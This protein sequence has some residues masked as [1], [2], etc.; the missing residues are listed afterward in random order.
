MNPGKHSF[1]PAVSEPTVNITGDFRVPGDKSLSHRALMAGHLTVGQTVIK[2]LLRA[3]D[4]MNTLQAMRALGSTI[5]DRQQ[6]DEVTVNGL[7]TGFSGEPEN[8]IDFGN[9]GTGARL[10]M[11][12]C[13]TSCRFSVFTGDVSLRRRPMNRV[14]DPLKHF[15]TEFYG[16]EGGF[17]PL[18]VKGSVNPRPAE[19]RSD[20]PS[21]QIKSAF[22]LAAL[23]APGESVF[24]EAEP[25]RDHT[26]K[27][28]SAFGADIQTT[29]NEQGEKTIRVKGLPSLTPQKLDIPGDP[30]SAAFFIVAALITPGSEITVRNVL[31]NPY[32]T[33]LF[34]TLREMGADLTI[35]NIRETGGEQ[36]G[37]ITAKTSE[38]TGVDVP[39]ERAPSMIDEYPILAVAAAAAKGDTV[40]RGLKELRVKESDRLNAIFNGLQAIGVST[41]I[42]EPDT[43]IVAGGSVIP[44]GGKIHTHE[45][46]RIAM[47]FM[48]AGAAARA[49]IEID[50]TN[51]I[52]TS[53][54]EFIILAERVGLKINLK[55]P[56]QVFSCD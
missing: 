56:Y 46:H 12:I 4:V 20:I 41:R 36:V 33:G 39:A 50:D 13:A 3:G 14:T 7:G 24:I 30:S 43:L 51:F 21:A 23:N 27:M 11:G 26:E 38:L 52:A 55:E 32:R 17:L 40:M 16:R 18:C 47:S 29:I 31:L 48:I 53:F 44:G 22:I 28:F 45:D 15:G 19:Y 35:F 1:Q 37:D 9:S 2:G 49:A 25:A 34:T 8:V 5:I 10:T 42:D 6:T 54:P